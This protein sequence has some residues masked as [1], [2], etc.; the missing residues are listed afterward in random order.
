MTNLH[1]G[2]ART[3]AM[4]DATLLAA[5]LTAVALAAAVAVSMAIA[6]SAPVLVESSPT[7]ARPTVTPLVHQAHLNLDEPH[8]IC[9]PLSCWPAVPPDLPVPGAVP[10]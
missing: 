5:E 7:H 6:P 4:T 10:R 8:T 2:A 9:S 3:L 1:A